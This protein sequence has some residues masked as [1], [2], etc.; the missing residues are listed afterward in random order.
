MENRNRN[1]CS[2]WH[3]YMDVS[4]T[5]ASP[6]PLLKM[7]W[8]IISGFS[9]WGYFWCSEFEQLSKISHHMESSSWERSRKPCLEATLAGARGLHVGLITFFLADSAF[10]H[11]TSL[12]PPVFENRRI[13]MITSILRGRGI[14]DGALK[15]RLRD[16]P[17]RH[18][19]E[20]VR[21]RWSCRLKRSCG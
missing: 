11:D 4:N 15:R 21:H 7:R 12:G 20:V 16:H 14:E 17:P 3:F 6:V 2:W 5:K 1:L 13:M 9:T 8:W 19:R 10:H 18:E